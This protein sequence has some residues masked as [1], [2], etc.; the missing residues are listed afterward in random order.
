[1]DVATFLT[2]FLIFMLV[3]QGIL[4]GNDL[5]ELGHVHDG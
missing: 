2:V 3:H 5:N 1:M 4:R